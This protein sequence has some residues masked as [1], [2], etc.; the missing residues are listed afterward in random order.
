MEV[1]VKV[2]AEVNSRESHE[3]KVR[4][5]VKGKKR[6]RHKVKERKIKMFGELR[7]HARPKCSGSNAGRSWPLW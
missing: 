4:A 1:K 6:E 2:R 5:K 3:V 7:W